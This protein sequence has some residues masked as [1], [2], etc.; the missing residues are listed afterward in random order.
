MAVFKDEKLSARAKLR[1]DCG[2][3]PNRKNRLG[4]IGCA[5][6]ERYV[7]IFESKKRQWTHSHRRFANVAEI[8]SAVVRLV[9]ACRLT[10]AS[11]T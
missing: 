3:N 11:A 4:E 5:K 7:A 1:R 2:M 9:A 10:K 8:G 6:L